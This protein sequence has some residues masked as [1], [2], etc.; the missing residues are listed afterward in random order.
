MSDL[1]EFNFFKKKLKFNGATFALIEASRQVPI[2]IRLT[3][4][5]KPIFI[6]EQLP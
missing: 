2:R 6:T 4:A 5:M 1:K 3:S